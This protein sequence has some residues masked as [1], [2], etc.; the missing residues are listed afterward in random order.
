MFLFNEF[1]PD[2]AVRIQGNLQTTDIRTV[3]ASQIL[4]VGLTR[5]EILSGEYLCR[6]M[7]YTWCAPVSPVSM[8]MSLPGLGT[9]ST[10]DAYSLPLLRDR[11]KRPLMYLT[12]LTYSTLP[13]YLTRNKR[14]HSSK[15]FQRA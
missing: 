15:I 3:H 14:E 13:Y 9:Q 1:P 10:I 12:H 5:I 11:Y 7:L 4:W 2:H 8:G 6:D